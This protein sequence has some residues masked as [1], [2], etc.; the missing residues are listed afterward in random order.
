MENRFLT[1]CHDSVLIGN[2]S[3][4]DRL[5]CQGNHDPVFNVFTTKLIMS[6]FIV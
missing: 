1:C 2:R 3:E 4:S 5:N 6:I